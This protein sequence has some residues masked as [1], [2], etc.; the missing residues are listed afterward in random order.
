ME[1]GISGS[2]SEPG[3]PAEGPPAAARP[4]GTARAEGGARLHYE[5]N[6]PRGN[7]ASHAFTP[8]ALLLPAEEHPALLPSGPRRSQTLLSVTWFAYLW[9][10]LRGACLSLGLI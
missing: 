8:C 4:V 6:W 7:P 5:W 1:G 10:G 9:P 3:S 2:S